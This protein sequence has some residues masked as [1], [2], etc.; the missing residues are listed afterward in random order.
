MRFSGTLDSTGIE[1]SLQA[2]SLTVMLDRVEVLTY[3]RAGRLWSYR[4]G[5][6]TLRRGMSGRVLEKWREGGGRR[7]RWLE[8]EEAARLLDESSTRMRA[9]AGDITAGRMRWTIHPEGDALLP[10]LERAA[11]FDARAAARDEARFHSIYNPIGILPPDQ[12]LAV[13]LQATTGCSFNT[14]TFCNFY[15]AQPFRI[16]PAEEFRAHARAVRAYLAEGLALRRSIFLGEANALAMP[17]G[18]LAEL[19]AIAREEIGDPSAL[20]LVAGQ[21]LPVSAFLDAFSGRKKSVDQYRR[22]GALG[23][24]RVSIGL[25]SGHDPLLKLV[26]KPGHAADAIE[27]VRALKTAGIAVS[28]IVLIG[29]GGDRYAARHVADTASA[30]NAMPLGKGDILYFSDLVEHGDTA[31]PAQARAAGIQPLDPAGREAQRQMIRSGIKFGT[32]K[33]IVSEYDIREF[34]Y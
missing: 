21:A 3:D 17:F 28:V 13:V 4:R 18:R 30:L 6:R 23:L 20:P 14:C 19:I 25:E 32:D 2:G 11:R 9:L 22:L 10:A 15:A 34:V 5:G 8:P 16:R 12:Y 33:P 31:Y 27:T 29:L 24:R 7:R 26:R 1:G